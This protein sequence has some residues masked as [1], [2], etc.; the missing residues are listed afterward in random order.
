MQIN[1]IL[2]KIHVY[3]VFDIYSLITCLHS[4]KEKPK[5]VVLIDSLPALYLSFVCFNNNDGKLNNFSKFE[6]KLV[7]T[8]IFFF[9]FVLH[10]S[11]MFSSKI[12]M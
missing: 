11:Y 9:R 5:P 12:L 7:F 2:K 3:S 1:F 10:E 6:R 8:L 4:L